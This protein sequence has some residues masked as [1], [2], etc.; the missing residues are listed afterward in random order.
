MNPSSPI[1]IVIPHVDVSAVLAENAAL[2]AENVQLKAMVAELQ[3]MGA[4]ALAIAGDLNDP[5]VPQRLVDQALPEKHESVSRRMPAAMGVGFGHV[6]AG[7]LA[8]PPGRAP[9]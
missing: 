5:L 8:G 7:F 2:R 9:D 4:Q 6:A 3:A 1:P